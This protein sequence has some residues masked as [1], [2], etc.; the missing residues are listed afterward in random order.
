[1]NLIGNT[2][3][4]LRALESEYLK[5]TEIENLLLD[6]NDITSIKGI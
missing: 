1:M 6:D 2:F 5:H 3:N 4:D